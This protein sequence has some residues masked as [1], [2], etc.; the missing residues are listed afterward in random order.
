MPAIA[1]LLV[2]GLF[3][4]SGIAILPGLLNM[5]TIDRLLVRAWPPG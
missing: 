4:R 5:P 2:K 3:A 1:E